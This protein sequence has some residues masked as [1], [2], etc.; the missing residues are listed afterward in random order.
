MLQHSLCRFLYK[1]LPE[2]KP[3]IYVSLLGAMVA[4]RIVWGAVMFCIMG[5]D[6]TSFGF[7]AFWT[8]AVLNAIPGIILQVV[9][10]PIL[11]MI[12]NNP[13]ITKE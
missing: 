6:T 8:G 1:H 9:L 11:V 2:K 5:F 12:L 4:G 3:F 7:T 13:K 10:I